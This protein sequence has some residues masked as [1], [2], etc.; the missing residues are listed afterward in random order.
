MDWWAK[1]ASH[2]LG[3]VVIKHTVSY[4]ICG[5]EAPKRRR[6]YARG[7]MRSYREL[8]PI[9][10]GKNCREIPRRTITY[11]DRLC[12]ERFTGGKRIR[13]EEQTD[14]N[15]RFQ[16]KLKTQKKTIIGLLKSEGCFSIGC[17][18]SKAVGRA[19]CGC[20]KQAPKK[21]NRNHAF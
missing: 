11:R 19:L 17:S 8:F 16:T 3:A 15:N 1:N 6:L 14:S 18:S 10:T 13:S 9:S 12:E 5:G 21:E 20:R 7:D 2:F 4:Y